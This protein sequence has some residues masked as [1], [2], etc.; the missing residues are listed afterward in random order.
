MAFRQAE[1]L[2]E[3]FDLRK[4]CNKFEGKINMVFLVFTLILLQIMQ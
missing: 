4:F 2:E 1:I 3:M